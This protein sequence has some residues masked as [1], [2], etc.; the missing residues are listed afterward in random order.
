MSPS[1]IEPAPRG[2]ARLLRELQFDPR[3][4]LYAVD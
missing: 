1:F 2:R 4:E 3:A